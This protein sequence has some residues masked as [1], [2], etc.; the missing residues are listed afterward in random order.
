MDEEQGETSGRGQDLPH[1]HL[2]HIRVK[3]AVPLSNEV[4]GNDL[5][6]NV[7]LSQTR[8]QLVQGL[9]S[10][11][12]RDTK[13]NLTPSDGEESQTNQPGGPGIKAPSEGEAFAHSVDML[14]LVSKKLT[15]LLVRAGRVQLRINNLDANLASELYPPNFAPKAVPFEE[16]TSEMQERWRALDIVF[17][18]QRTKMAISFEKDNAEKANQEVENHLGGPTKFLREANCTP[19]GLKKLAELWDN[20]QAEGV[21]LAQH[22][23]ETGTS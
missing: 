1:G 10:S 2:Y 14:K 18:K 6:H 4:L 11:L 17:W 23:L 3:K 16:A 7:V 15:T 9:L 21:S 5:Q 22:Q 13:P 12:R 8:S 19:L 20:A